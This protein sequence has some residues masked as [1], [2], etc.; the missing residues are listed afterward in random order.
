MLYE[1]EDGQ[2]LVFFDENRKDKMYYFDGAQIW[3]VIDSLEKKIE[4]LPIKKRNKEVAIHFLN[5]ALKA[6]NNE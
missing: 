4:L 2:K 3:E 6:L 1:F 5:H